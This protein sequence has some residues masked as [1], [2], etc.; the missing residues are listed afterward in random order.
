MSDRTRR[1]QARKIESIEL[2][3]L[4][5]DPDLAVRAAGQPGGVR[6]VDG[7]GRLL[8]RMSIPSDPL[9]E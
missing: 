3:T 7:D 8:F 4:R 5:D 6:V 9:P 1:A 2:G